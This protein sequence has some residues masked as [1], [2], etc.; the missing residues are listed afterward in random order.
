MQ[1]IDFF[2]GPGRPGKCDVGQGT[3]LGIIKPHLVTSRQAG[4]VLAEITP[5]FD[6]VCM[7]LF[8]MSKPAAAEFFEV[9]RGVIPASDYS[10]M[11][12]E[13]CSGPCLVL[14]VALPC[15]PRCCCRL[16][17]LCRYRSTLGLGLLHAHGK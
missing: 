8:T 10:G 16:S 6:I 4:T 11:V 17:M 7:E 3:T 12:E 15:V 1:E 2:F 14:E 9:Y 5:H 13:L